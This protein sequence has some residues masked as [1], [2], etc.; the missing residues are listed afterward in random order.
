M[1]FRSAKSSQN[2]VFVATKSGVPFDS[3]RVQ[4]EAAALQ[5]AGI[6][7]L[8]TLQFRLQSF[9]VLAPPAAKTSPVLTD[10]RAPVEALV[11]S[12]QQ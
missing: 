12:G 4:R 6:M 10:D 11:G 1:L 3:A 2:V 8:P 7:K 5:R 9:T